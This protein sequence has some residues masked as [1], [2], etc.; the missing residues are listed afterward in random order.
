MNVDQNLIWTAI[1][2]VLDGT[3]SQDERQLVEKWLNESDVNQKIYATIAN[4]GYFRNL[5]DLSEVKARLRQKL[6]HN[7]ATLA[8]RR[9]I[10]LYQSL[11]AASVVLLVVIGG[12]MF[13]NEK[14][15]QL[16]ASVETVTSNGC[17][18]HITLSDGT[19]VALNS[20]SYLKYPS[21]FADGNRE[22]ELV[23]EAYFEVAKD[24]NHPFIVH[25]QDVQVRVLGTHFNV[26]SFPEDDK[27]VTTLL[28][29]AVQLTTSG[30]KSTGVNQ[31]LKPNQQ[32]VF[33]KR[34]GKSD[35]RTVEAML[36]A[37][38]KDNQY[39]FENERFSQIAHELERGYNMKIIIKNRALREETFSGTFEKK[40]SFYRILDAMKLYRGFDYR[41]HQDTVSIY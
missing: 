18:S 19:V 25:S 3:A 7:I 36:Y 14:T 35:V 22:V 23:G 21:H 39:Y 8:L 9:K 30:A 12:W 26:K 27:I 40:E 32:L 2:N 13:M 1:T 4:V 16:T 33:N 10:R 37:S 41:V 17:K 5:G 31:V 6:E 34:S 29:G 15:S 20:G 38:W 28:E 24:K 11:A